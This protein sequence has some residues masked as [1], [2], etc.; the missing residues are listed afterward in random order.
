MG[1]VAGILVGDAGG[2]FARWRTQ[3][4]G[5]QVLVDVF[6]LGGELLGFRGVGRV[7]LEEFGIL[8]HHG[9]ASGGVGDDCIEAVAEHGVDIL[10]REFAGGIELPGV[11]VKRTAT[12]L[13][14]GHDDLNAVHGEDADGGAVEFGEGD[15]GDASSEKG[16]AGTTLAY[17]GIGRSNLAEEEIIFDL[18]RE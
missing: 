1:E 10:A 18:R 6:Y 4:D 3:A 5:G 16:D 14:V 9:A 11:C 15:A 17:S 2:K 12:S 8:L 7:V 13:I